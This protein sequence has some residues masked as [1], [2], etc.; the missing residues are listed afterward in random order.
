MNPVILT[1]SIITYI[2]S[3]HYAIA[4]TP[5]DTAKITS[6]VTLETTTGTLHGT[7]LVPAAQKKMPLIILIA[8]SGPT[9]RNGNS[10]SGKNNAL[11]FLAEALANNGIATLRYDK[12]GVAESKPAAIAEKDL[13]FENFITDATGWINQLKTDKRFT[14]IVVAGHSEGSLIGMMAAHNAGPNAFISIAGPGQSADKILKGQLQKQLGGFMQTVGPMIDSLAAGN[15]VKKV[16]P[17]LTS[18]FRPNLQ[19]YLI[20]WMHYDPATE[21]KKLLIPA[22]IIQGTTDIQVSLDDANALKTAYPSAKLVVIEGMNHIFKEVSMD[23]QQNLATYVNPTLPIV[24]KLADEIATFVK[25]L[26]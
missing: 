13:R 18:L 15:T 25:G 8:G 17:A 23:L 4:G 11:Q 9:D 3:M 10:A 26:K 20:S 19:P 22:L 2:L 12:R 5:A 16:P 21:I 7:L 1:A 6:P 24:P 14:R